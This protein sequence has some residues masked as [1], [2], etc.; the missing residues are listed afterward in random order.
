MRQIAALLLII[1]AAAA[2]RA[3]G[4]AE[5]E[6][7][8]LVQNELK[9]SQEKLKQTREEQQVVLGKLVVITQ[10]L[11]QANRSLNRAKAKIEVNE[12]KIGELVVEQKKTEED[13]SRKTGR[14]QLR[15][16]EAFKRGGLNYLDLLFSSRSVSDLLNRLYFFEKV[17]A[18]DVNL[19]EGVRADL[20]QNRSRRQSLTERTNEIKELAQVIADNK[21]K[22]TA[23]VAEKKKALDE[24]KARE[25]E[26]AAKVAELQKSSIELEKLIL[27]KIA[28]RSRA[29]V[30][31]KSTGEMIW[32]VQGRVT[33][34]FGAPHRLQGRHTGLD[35]AAPYGSP[36]MAADAGEVIFAGWWDGY[37]KA[38]VIDHGRGVATVYAHMSRLYPSVGASI[39]KGQTIGL[40]GMTGYTTGPH[41]HFEVRINGVPKNP[42]KFLP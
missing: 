12:N 35:I 19:I 33:L 20:R 3:E 25:A 23:D 15:V 9:T 36:I 29:G 28:E 7:L 31:I 6:K 39:A 26:Y 10:D 37:G 30:K 1:L 11:R 4:L 40:I 38:I 27:K 2:V 18:S 41:C 13:L 42:E 22:I 17:V 8:K 5:Q 16:R 14:L 21:Q 32:P 34:R 24:L